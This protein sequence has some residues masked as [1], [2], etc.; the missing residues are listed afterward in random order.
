MV[1]TLTTPMCF[2]SFPIISTLATASI[3]LPMSSALLTVATISPLL[4][5]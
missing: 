4:I 3:M 5:T 1:G 2:G